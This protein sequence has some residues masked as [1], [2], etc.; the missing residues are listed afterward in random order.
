MKRSRTLGAIL[1]A[2]VVTAPL[3]SQTLAS[4]S[5]AV[6]PTPLEI[7]QKALDSKSQILSEIR[8]FR[9]IIQEC[10]AK[11]EAGEVSA[12][13]TVNDRRGI[14]LYLRGADIRPKV[15]TG[16]VKVPFLTIED[17]ADS[18]FS[19][20]RRYQKLHTCPE[21]LKIAKQLGFYELCVR[22]IEEPRTLSE[23]ERQLERKVRERLKQ[24]LNAGSSSSSR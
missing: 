9:R 10:E 3:T 4:V 17:I 12:C 22:F 15:E 20:L 21:G 14:R 13:P 5:Q 2:M 18:D 7:R 1:S 16:A 8:E 24:I 6:L 11:K 19:L 23:R